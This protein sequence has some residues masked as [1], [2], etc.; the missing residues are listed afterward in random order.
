M[1][2]WIYVDTRKPLAGDKVYL[3]M[4]ANAEVAKAWFERYNSEG[5]AFAP[6]FRASLIGRRPIVY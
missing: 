5:V 2:V 3:N 1:T 4:F 6:G